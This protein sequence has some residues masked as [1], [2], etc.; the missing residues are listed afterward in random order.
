MRKTLFNLHLYAGLICGLFLLVASVSGLA[1]AFRPELDPG[2]NADFWH[3]KSDTPR[4]PLDA[5]VH[6][7]KAIYPNGKISYVHLKPSPT[8]AD[9]VRFRDGEE[10]FLNPFTAQQLEIRNRETAFFYVMEKLHRYLLLGKQGQWITGTAS[11]A[12]GVLIIT[13]IYLWWPKKSKPL[14]ASFTLDRKLHGRGWNVNLHKVVGIYSSVIIAFA[15]FTG[16]AE[17]LNWVGKTY[18]PDLVG[19]DRELT[20]ASSAPLGSKG[21]ITFEAEWQKVQQDIGPYQ[22][23]HF[24]WPTQPGGAMTIEYVPAAAEH[25]NALS[26]LFL[27]G[28]TGEV[29]KRLPYAEQPAWSR[30]YMWLLPI[31]LGTVAGLPS[32]IMVITGVLGTMF[33]IVTGFW[34]YYRRK[35]N[36]I[37]RPVAAAVVREKAAV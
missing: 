15:V 16:G 5:I 19:R 37:P 22:D 23:V 12:L 31:H 33:L 18:F 21:A 28:Y 11:L 2:Q 8:S 17:Y 14:K 10:L 13:G 34:L 24:G 7:A 26:Y 25:P 29:L 1:L 4:L 35:L 30:F 3:L 6:A 27:D 36:P 9:M 32:R 20:L